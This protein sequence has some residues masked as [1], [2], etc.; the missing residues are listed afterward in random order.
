[1][2]AYFELPMKFSTP[3]NAAVWLEYRI[4]ATIKPC[5]GSWLGKESPAYQA[6]I[7]DT[8]QLDRLRSL[9]AVYNEESNLQVDE[10]SGESSLYF[11]ESQELQPVGF[12][13]EI[14]KV[15]SFSTDNWTF[16]DNK[17]FTTK[18]I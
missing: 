8:E 14:D 16:I 11:I 5:R 10:N 4:K 9:C 1:M 17:Y 6:D 2:K 15:E 7:S 13:T 3:F 18:E 12:W